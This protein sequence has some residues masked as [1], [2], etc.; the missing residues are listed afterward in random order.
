M[1]TQQEAEAKQPPNQAKNS[2]FHEAQEE[3]RPGRTPVRAVNFSAFQYNS[4]ISPIN[5]SI[6]P[7]LVTQRA[8]PLSAELRVNTASW[9]SNHNV[10]A[11]PSPLGH[12]SRLS[13][14]MDSKNTLPVRSSSI[15]SLGASHFTGGSLSPASAMSSPNL[16]PLSDITPLPSPVSY[17]PG[18]WSR[19]RTSMEE[20]RSDQLS[21]EIS[22]LPSTSPPKRRI[23]FGEKAF[24]A[25]ESSLSAAAAYNRN[26]S[27]S[28]YVAAAGQTTR[29]RNVAVS[30]SKTP[31]SKQT[32]TQSMQREEYLAIQRGISALPTQRP[33]TPPESN[34]SATSDAGSPPSYIYVKNID[35]PIFEAPMLKNGKMRQWVS[36][37]LLGTGSFSRV[38]LATSD[39]CKT[40][41]PE[42]ELNPKTLVAV[43][44]CEHGPAGGADEKRIEESLKREIEILKAINHPSLI[45]LKA[46]NILEKRAYLILSYCPGGDMFELV[47]EKMN[48]LTPSLVR[49]IFAELV[50]A[51]QYLHE[52]LIV[53]RDIK[54]ESKHRWYSNIHN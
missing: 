9:H 42:E 20:T 18:P 53:H 2:E 36:V 10:R 15:K 19:T 46:V 51:V 12:R 23:A 49:R 35:T 41:L 25:N 21:P 8:S 31:T 43:K 47:S 44:V 34:K 32:S 17:S 26:R 3:D 24:V 4:N 38:L 16:G 11:T 6:A 13:R 28:E 40:G 1:T 48:L 14:E 30:G 45:R 54:L 37:K 22:S 29:N 39:L 27:F 5:T 52:K 50:A 7:T 33:P